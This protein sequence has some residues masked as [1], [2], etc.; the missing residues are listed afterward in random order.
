MLAVPPPS[1]LGSPQ[2]IA[3][4]I[5]VGKIGESVVPPLP[6]LPLPLPLPLPAGAAI[7]FPPH[8]VD[9]YK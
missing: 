2:S 9:A 5:L 1:D 7:P 3:P 8:A 4:L 6:P